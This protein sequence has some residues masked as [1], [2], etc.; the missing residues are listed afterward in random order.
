MK[1]TK[2]RTKLGELHSPVSTELEAVVE[3][4]RSED[5]KAVANKITAIALNSRLAEEQGAPRYYIEDCDR[6]PYLVF[7]ATF[8]RKGVEQPLTLTQLLLLNIPCPEGQRQV[9]DIKAR[10]AQLPYTL[11][12]FAGVSGVTLKVVVRCEYSG[13]VKP[14][15]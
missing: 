2:I 14:W 7:S 13:D 12:A 8:G 10:V 4:M 5:T 15:E 6:L 3:R 11:L 1:I 9:E